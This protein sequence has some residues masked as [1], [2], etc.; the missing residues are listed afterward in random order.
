MLCLLSFNFSVPILP[1]PNPSLNCLNSLLPFIFHSHFISNAF[2]HHNQSSPPAAASTPAG[3]SPSSQLLCST[4]GAC[5]G[6]WPSPRG[7]CCCWYGC[8]CSWEGPSCE[9][10]DHPNSLCSAHP[11]TKKLH[12]PIAATIHGNHGSQSL[13]VDDVQWVQLNKYGVTI[14]WHNTHSKYK[15]N[16]LVFANIFHELK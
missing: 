3:T 4:W 16:Y 10:S 11:S 1:S 9:W 8:S 2:R 5:F 13:H 15:H 6:G 14:L 7:S 12:K